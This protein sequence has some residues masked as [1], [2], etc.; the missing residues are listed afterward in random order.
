MISIVWADV[1]CF[2]PYI[3]GK[4]LIDRYATSNHCI[5][6]YYRT[7]TKTFI[8]TITNIH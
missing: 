7:T 4:W 6:L 3:N 2:H 8:S 5:E 1:T